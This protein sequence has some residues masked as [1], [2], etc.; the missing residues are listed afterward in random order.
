MK[1]ELK[2]HPAA[3]KPG[4]ALAM[5]FFLAFMSGVMFCVLN[6]VLVVGLLL[7]GLY[8]IRRKG[9]LGALLAVSLCLYLTPLET[10]SYRGM[11]VIQWNLQKLDGSFRMNRCLVQG[12]LLVQARGK[13]LF[14]P[15]YV[16]IL[17][18][19][20]GFFEWEKTAGFGY[21][22]ET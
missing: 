22:E 19:K 18:K 13:V 4:K 20:K 10:L 7:A 5:A 9:W 16:G 12:I 8:A 15:L 6:S 1:L 3:D 11:D 14:L 2:F 21:L 17:R